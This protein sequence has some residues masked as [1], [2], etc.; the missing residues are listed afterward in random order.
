M[1]NSKKLIILCV[2]VVLAVAV[3]IGTVII[4]NADAFTAERFDYSGV[5]YQMVQEAPVSP[6]YESSRKGLLLS[7]YDGG[8]TAALKG[9][10][11]G[12]FNAEMKATTLDAVTPDLRAYSLI[13][14]DIAT[15]ERFA[16]TI[17]DK[18]TELHAYVTVGED[19][20]GIFYNADTSWDNMPHGYTTLQNQSGVYTRILTKGVTKVLFD[21]YTMEVS[22]GNDAGGYTL[23][24][25][26]NEE[27]IDGKHF[28]H[29]IDGMGNY[30]VKLMFTNVTAGGKGE[31]T[32][33]SINGEDYG[34]ANLPQAQPTVYTGAVHN[35]VAGSAYELP[36]PGVYDSY[37]QLTADDITYKVYNEAGAELA[38]GNYAAGAAF[39]PDKAGSYY[40]YY[41]LEGDDGRKGEAYIKIKAYAQDNVSCIFTDVT[42]EGQTVGLH[43]AVMLPQRQVTSNLFAEGFAADAAV[44]VMHNGTAVEAPNGRLEFTKLGE[45][46]VV[47]SYT[48]GGKEYKAAPII[49]TVSDDVAGVA[50]TE[51]AET[52]YLGDTVTIPQATVYLKGQSGAAT[53]AVILPDGTRVTESS[54]KLELVGGYTVEYT[55]DVAGVK[56]TVQR[57]FT[58]NRKV[59]DLFT[60]SEKTTITFDPNMGNADLPG[61]VLE[62]SGN[63]SYV[64]YDVDLSDNTKNDV[65]IDL[66]AVASAVGTEDFTGFYVTLTDKLNPA[67]YV[68]VRVHKGSGNASGGSFVKARASNQSAFTGWYKLPDWNAGAPYPYT[69]QLE[70]ATAH[71][72][73]GFMTNHSFANSG[74]SKDFRDCTLELRWDTAEKALYAKND[75]QFI[76][77]ENQN[78]SL[79]V[80][81]DDPACFTNIWGGFTDNSQ[82]ELKIMPIGVASSA[83]L[84]VFNIDGQVFSDSNVADTQAPSLQLD[85]QGMTAAPDAKT[86]TAYKLLDLIVSDNFSAPSM[87]KTAVTVMYGNTAV[88]VKDGAFVPEKD[89]YYTVTYTA[90][91]SYGNASKLTH[92]IRARGDIQGVTATVQGQWQAQAEYGFPIK[93]PAYTGEGGTG[94]FNYYAKVT[95][96]GQTEEITGN[97]YTPM[98]EG[99]YVVTLYAQDYIGQ[100]ATLTH[101]YNV[102]YR[103]VFVVNSADFILPPAF[104]SGSTFVFDDYTAGYYSAVGAEMTVVTAQI[105]VEDADGVRTLDSTTYVPKA[106]ETVTQAK[107]RF[108]FKATVDGKTIENVVEKTAPIRTIG[109]SPDFMTQYFVLENATAVARNQFLT[110]T[111]AGN[112][113]MKMTYLR[114]V[115]MEEFV[116]E[117]SPT[118]IDSQFQSN[119]D[120]IRIT[121]TDR[122]DPSIQVQLVIRKNGNKLA[123]S[124]NGG[125]AMQMLGSITEQ[126]TQNLVVSYFNAT[127]TLLGVE[128]STLGS[129]KNT[130][131]GRKFQGFTSGEAYVSVEVLGINGNA[132]LNLIAINNQRFFSTVR[133]SGVPQVYVDGSYSGMFVAGA[134][135]TLPTARAYDVLN[136]TSA[137][138]VTVT[139][140]DGSYVTAL[141]GTVLNAAPANK[142]YVIAPTAM[143]RYLVFYSSTDESGQYRSVEKS[144]V[145]Y[146]N[147]AP[148]VELTGTLPE[149]VWVGTTIRVPE[150]TVKDNGDVE[151][152]Q[153]SVKYRDASGIL[154]TVENGEFVADAAGSY[155]LMFYMIDENGAYNTQ[156]FTVRA[157]ARPDSK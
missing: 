17:E 122:H 88:T 67:N 22:L 84:K 57:T 33:Y 81:F 56:G 25:D 16:L 139:A 39:T 113:S 71:V 133:D 54:V 5:K 154:H 40:I 8:A 130:L 44:T 73:G 86:G 2:T 109:Q 24:W 120:A 53:H 20:T 42:L 135:I 59:E 136:S 69:N 134:E 96:N 62:M 7:A 116:L 104:I 93:L 12:Q 157:Y 82:V 156:S 68:T 19:Q 127:H 106:S 47:Y 126:T 26:L 107:I 30:T 101:T 145:I 79:V 13:F 61:V 65:L 114:P 119:Y 36:V 31:L 103:P 34:T 70:N 144:L 50:A 63:S 115:S 148:T 14:E 76:P 90:T 4:A 138:A 48:V 80:D 125:S 49:F 105:E 58:A 52:Y 43:S 74:L 29:I 117:M 66:T 98:G 35:A 55:Y 38:S 92:E 95:H 121:L 6:N 85:L 51:L 151:K 37:N 60:S 118:V 83:K 32:L 140:P 21:P 41:C 155:V 146:D 137:A 131:D 94:R 112:G 78:E 27:I 64:T 110:F 100:T 91:D 152:V 128:N 97:T 72:Y 124:V 108:I 75:L 18:G 28:G 99:E 102:T 46:Q 150:Y 15:A 153:V 147:V 10:F 142:N 143:G 45:Y 9:T 77:A 11:Q 111:A 23:I 87:I 123:F 3:L 149:R 132:A 141:D 89:G 129:V 1:K